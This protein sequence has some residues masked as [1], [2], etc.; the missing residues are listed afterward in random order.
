MIIRTVL[1]SMAAVLTLTACNA[2]KQNEPLEAEAAPLYTQLG[3]DPSWQ[4]VKDSDALRPHHTNTTKG[5][6]GSKI[7]VNNALVE[8][9]PYANNPI[10]QDN[11]AIH[12][13]GHASIRRDQFERW[14]RWYQEDGNTQVFRLFKG[15]EN[16]R[17]KR[18]NAARIESFSTKDKWAPAEGVWREWAGRFTII[19]SAG[20]ALPHMCSIFQAKGNNVDHWS[21]MIRLDEHGNIWYVP[22]KEQPEIGNKKYIV[23]KNMNGKGFDVRVRDNG[24]DYEV[25]IDNKKVGF[26]QWERTEEIGFRWGIYVGRSEVTDDIMLF[27]SGVTM[28]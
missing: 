20:C 25:Y 2:Q 4:T 6:K 17:N 8:V 26:G 15:E 19:K 16:L 14:T 27:A 10:I 3:D 5:Y 12:T 18:E 7:D 11:L 9:G 23:A 21:V 28:H 1:I 13:V 22:R 24:M